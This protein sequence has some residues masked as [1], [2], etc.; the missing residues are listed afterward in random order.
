MYAAKVQGMAHIAGRCC[1]AE[2]MLVLV[3]CEYANN[4]S[5]SH[6]DSVVAAQ[7]SYFCLCF[8]LERSATLVVSVL[9]RGRLS[10]AREII[11]NI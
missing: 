5:V 10:Y 6:S 8:I 3:E 7:Y 9:F 2:S 4:L 11:E 1:L